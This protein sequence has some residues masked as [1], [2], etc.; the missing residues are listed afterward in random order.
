MRKKKLIKAFNDGVKAGVKPLKKKFDEISESQADNIHKAEQIRREQRKQQKLT[1]RV[2]DDVQ[3]ND[4]KVREVQKQTDSV[5]DRQKR[6]QQQINDMK[7]HMK[8]THSICSC[9]REIL[10]SNQIVCSNC[11][12]FVDKLPYE[13]KSFDMDY[14]NIGELKDLAEVI[15]N[16]KKDLTWIYPEMEDKFVKMKK[17]QEI[18]KHA[19]EQRDENVTHYNTIHKYTEEFFKKYNKKKIEI[20]LVGT[21]KAGKSSLINALIGADVAS[22][23]ATPETSIL[24]KYRTTENE[25]YLKI[26]FYTEKEWNALWNT[27]KDTT[28]FKDEY[29]KT[30]AE[31]VRYEF[32]G[33]KPRTI[34][35]NRDELTD[36]I[37]EWTRSDTPKHFFVKEIEVGYEGDSDK[38]PHDVYLVDTPGLNDPVKYRSDITREYIKEADWIIACTVVENLSTA[39]TFKE[40]ERIRSNKNND[41]SRMFIVANKRD[42][43]TVKKFEEKKEEF[44]KILTDEFKKNNW[45]EYYAT[46]HFFVISAM[47]HKLINDYCKGVKLDDESEEELDAMLRRCKMDMSDL[48]EDNKLDEAL[49]YAGV[50]NLFNRLND[51]IIKRKRKDI[52]T[53]IKLSYYDTM[54]KINDIANDN[55]KK[56]NDQLQQYISGKEA[57]EE[58][59]E[60]MKKELKKFKLTQ[61]HLENIIENLEIEAEAMD[62]E[63]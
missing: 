32:L 10:T 6:Q 23:N 38:F 15:K 39:E 51:C 19:A 8:G 35:F 2:I 17:I 34:N 5:S 25:N 21:V 37:M 33:S 43:L 16:S 44:L 46:S 24:T 3:T 52:L 59:I 30:N 12:E 29:D 58:E 50:N 22:V 28:H 31:S 45:D 11:G 7:L 14:K 62:M 56:T 13:L 40:L 49:S 48:Q 60:T 55:I 61:R 36:K 1:N 9:C 54:R 47:G 57:T 27:V 20:A 63:V 26:K 18:A 42:Q 53:E 41:V 4:S